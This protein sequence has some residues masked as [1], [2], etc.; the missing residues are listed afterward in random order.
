MKTEELVGKMRTAE[1]VGYTF[2]T[3]GMDFFLMMVTRLDDV[4]SLVM[5]LGANFAVF[6]VKVMVDSYVGR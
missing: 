5:L 3:L 2:L 1:L 4:H 6:G